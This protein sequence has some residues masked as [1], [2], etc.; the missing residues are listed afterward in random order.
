MVAAMIVSNGSRVRTGDVL[1]EFD[2]QTQMKNLLDRQ[3]EYDGLE[4]QIQRKQADH[5]AALATDETELK[6]ARLP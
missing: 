3:A 4:R 1:L 5:A 6:G 2:T